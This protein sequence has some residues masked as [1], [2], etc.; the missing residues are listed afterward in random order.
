[1]DQPYLTDMK[2]L[3]ERAHDHMDEGPRT[4]GDGAERQTVLRLLNEALAAR[5][6]GALRY[7][8]HYFMASD[9]HAQT[10]VDAGIDA[11][12]VASEF[13]HHAREEQDHADLIAARVVRL[14]SSP[15]EN[16]AGELAHSYGEYVSG[17][18][19][20]EIIEEDLVAERIANDAYGE[21]IRY[22]GHDDPTSRRML[23]DIRAAEEEHIDDLRTL[24]EALSVDE[25]HAL[26]A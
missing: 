1:M 20:V 23:E 4:E 19:L 8:R 21:M 26:R 24:K 10:F 7:K 16:P 15:D 14:G 22:I 17:T 11:R 6:V 13:L 9:V 12:S 18:R 3:R 25:R 2:E 5:I